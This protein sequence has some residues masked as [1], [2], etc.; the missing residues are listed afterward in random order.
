MSR[1]QLIVVIWSLMISGF[2]CVLIPVIR[3]IADSFRKPTK[4]EWFTMFIGVTLILIGVSHLIVWAITFI[5]DLIGF[6]PI[7]QP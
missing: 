5:K 6:S 1:L 3:I 4:A 2:I 7:D